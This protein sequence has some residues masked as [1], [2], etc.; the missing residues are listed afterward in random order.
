M[1]VKLVV[2]SHLSANAVASSQ[3]T[4]NNQPSYPHSFT[5]KRLSALGS[6]TTDLVTLEHNKIVDAL[7]DIART[8]FSEVGKAT[9]RAKTLMLQCRPAI[10][11]AVLEPL[12]KML[13]GIIPK[14]S[15]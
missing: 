12:Q 10:D 9:E 13:S 5:R 7:E 4:R 15:G 11:S 8:K 6:K 14:V 1:A 3:N 2:V